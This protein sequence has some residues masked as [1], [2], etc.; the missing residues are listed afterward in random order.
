MTART[1]GP[2]PLRRRS[3]MRSTGPRRVGM[4]PAAVGHPRYTSAV[5]RWSKTISEDVA[6]D[7]CVEE[8]AVG[9][10]LLLQRSEIL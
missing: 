1:D 5:T 10:V 3:G 9:V 7:E 4:S 8:F 6:L 2:A